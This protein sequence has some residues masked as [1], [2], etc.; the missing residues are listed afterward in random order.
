MRRL[1]LA[2]PLMLAAGPAAANTVA[3]T[4]CIAAVKDQTGRTLS[5]FDAIYRQKFLAPDTVRWPGVECT[6]MDG[7]VRDLKIDGKPVVVAGWPSPEA[8]RSFQKLAAETQEAI[9]LL[10]TRQGLLQQRLIEAE[11]ALRQPGADTAAVEARVR[12]GIAEATG[13]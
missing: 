12:S 9:Q 2:I 10:Q 1:A 13:R 4:A 5:E 7:K 6:V 3:I 11:A 8:K